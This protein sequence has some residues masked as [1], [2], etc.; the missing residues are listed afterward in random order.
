MGYAFVETEYGSKLFDR[1]E[2]I[3]Q[4]WALTREQFEVTKEHYMTE[5]VN[6]VNQQF[7]LDLASIIYEE[8][9]VPLYS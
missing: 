7:N 5:K 9:N 2:M 8:M 4:I 3:Q 1:Y 6:I